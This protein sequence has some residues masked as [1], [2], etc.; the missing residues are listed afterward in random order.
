M[1]WSHRG[2][3]T[4]LCLDVGLEAGRTQGSLLLQVVAY[5]L[6]LR[7]IE[8]LV[9]QG[10]VIPLPYLPGARQG[11]K[12]RMQAQSRIVMSVRIREMTRPWILIRRG[13][14]GRTHR[15]EL[16]VA[17][18][19][20]YVSIAVDETGFVAAFPERTGSP[21]GSIDVSDVVPSQALH[22]SADGA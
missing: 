2:A 9:K 12:D 14:H 10:L 4:Q 6:H 16:D 19:R 15:V 21:V 11:G 1:R 17:M 5:L 7:F 22:H 13:H 3:S 8:H 20:Q 18:A